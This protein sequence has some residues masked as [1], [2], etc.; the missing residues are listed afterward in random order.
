LTKA[1]TAP[2][3]E[4]V[5]VRL[6]TL[7]HQGRLK[8]G[9]RLP[10]ERALA[11]RMRVSRAT[12]R[13]AL[14]AMQLKGLI[15]SRRGA[16][17]FIASGTPEDLADALHHLALQDIFEL[18]LLIEPS[19]AALAAERA[20]RQDL[21]RLGAILQQQEGELKEKRMTGLTDAAFHSALA[22]ATHNRALMQVGAT[23]MKVI[24]PSRNESLQTLERA[25]V[26]LASH[27]RI[28][29]AIQAGD[30][31][32]ARRAMEEHIRSIDPKLFGLRGI[33]RFTPLPGIQ[34]IR[35]VGGIH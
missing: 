6:A 5:M 13:E 16:G 4:E 11:E 15:E 18:R 14:R 23:L 8:P 33:G 29:D 17:S 35:T 26:S 21:H 27:R 7:L 9:D 12:I 2:V 10:S 24:S 3:Y 20:N 32:E 1:K 28:V 34:E 31:V 22:E 30:S 25:R 19:I